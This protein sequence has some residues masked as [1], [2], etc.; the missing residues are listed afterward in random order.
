MAHGNKKYFFEQLVKRGDL[1][2]VRP[3]NIYSLKNQIKLYKKLDDPGLEYDIKDLQN[4]EY[5][6]IRTSHKSSAIA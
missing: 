6:I 4:G 3:A 2:T 1:I 5:E